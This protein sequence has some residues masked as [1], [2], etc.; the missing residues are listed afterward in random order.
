MTNS[1][2]KLLRCPLC[3]ER[4][5]PSKIVEEVENKIEWGTIIC[6]GCETKYAVA[7]GIPIIKPPNSYVDPNE[8][9]MLN[10]A[11]T[12]RILVRD[13]VKQI[14]NGEI[15][16]TQK[17]LLIYRFPRPS[18]KGIPR[19]DNSF[20]LDNK[21]AHLLP[22]SIVKLIG[23]RN[24]QFIYWFVTKVSFTEKRYE[25]REK[26]I[27]EKLIK[28][29]SAVGFI[30]D[31]FHD[32]MHSSIYNYFTYRFGQPRFLAALSLFTTLP[33]EK[34]PILDIACGTGH[35]IHY[36]THRNSQQLV[37]GMERNFIK[38]YLAKRFIAPKGNFFCAEADQPL[39]FEKNSFSGIYCSD[40]FQYFTY[41]EGAVREMKRISAPNGVIIV[42]RI[43]GRQLP[44]YKGNA[45]ISPKQLKNYF[46]GMH[47]IILKEN[48]LMERYIQKLGPNM[49]TEPF[50]SELNDTNW[51]SIVASHRK[52]LFHNYGQFK[53]WPHA[54]G[55]L[56]INPLYHKNGRD[57]KGNFV[58]NFKFPSKWYE[59]ENHDWMKY[60]P[61]TVHLSQS[62]MNAIVKGIRT[63]EVN[64]LISKWVVIGMPEKYLLSGHN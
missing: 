10:T 6:I 51:I 4:L 28:E 33:E 40:A 43:S 59:Y 20:N 44:G 9:D 53:D 5:E 3:G 19:Q 23:R 34:N 2:L 14:E 41:K 27:Y 62:T 56:N 1:F 61:E 36:L 47:N 18:R 38:L 35:F 49:S 26:K 22:D 29:N 7:C 50:L 15:D 55:T 24:L 57:E 39:P 32:L 17:E 60:A 13:I 8:N 37:I 12:K 48:D 16:K 52:N 64:D 30:Y 42:A 11:L 58:L 63:P 21:L 31:Y 45:I 54:L 25:K 46:K